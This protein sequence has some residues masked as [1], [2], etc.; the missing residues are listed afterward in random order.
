MWVQ[1][2]DVIGEVMAYAETG[3]VMYMRRVCRAFNEEAEHAVVCRGVVCDPDA[4][5]YGWRLNASFVPWKLRMGTQ[6]QLWMNER[7]S[8]VYEYYKEKVWVLERQVSDCGLFELWDDRTRSSFIDEREWT[9]GHGRPLL[10]DMDFY[11]KMPRVFLTR[12]GEH[13]EE[14]SMRMVWDKR[15]TLE[16]WSVWGTE[17]ELIPWRVTSSRYL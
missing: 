11:V 12:Q 6:I 7:T 14:R 1:N 17:E 16:T 9:W 2:R 4:G 10:P 3:D 8:I 13:H 15:N 5:V